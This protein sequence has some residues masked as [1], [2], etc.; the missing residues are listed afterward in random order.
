MYPF[1]NSVFMVDAYF[2]K[3]CCVN[4]AIGDRHN[5]LRLNLAN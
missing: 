3:V 4:L 5:N 2:L 1:L